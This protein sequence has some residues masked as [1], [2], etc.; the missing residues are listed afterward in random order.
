MWLDKQRCPL[1]ISDEPQKRDF[2][3]KPDRLK[4]QSR[5]NPKIR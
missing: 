5:D 1:C 4:N 2:F 3:E